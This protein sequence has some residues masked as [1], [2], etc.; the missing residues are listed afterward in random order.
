M[1]ISFYAGAALLALSTTAHC[2]RP[3]VY[4][5][6]SQSAAVQSIDNAYCY[7]QARQQTGV[8]MTHFL[9]RPP[10]TKQVRLAPDA[11]KGASAPP[12]PA[13]RGASAAG[14][15]H[16]AKGSSGVPQASGA[17]AAS[18][19]GAPV[20]ATQGTA[21]GAMASPASAPSTNLP[22]LP[23]PEPPMASYWRA[24]GDCMQSRG[25]GM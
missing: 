15:A 13:P 23:P 6:R 1:K 22:P 4:P 18:G 17:L 5:M 21:S 7:W 9:Q 24:Y 20:S 3:P 2:Q 14:G 19:G 12:L 16:E 11:G 8:D 10:R 25:Y